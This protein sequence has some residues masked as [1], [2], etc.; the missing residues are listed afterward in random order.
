ML[1]D[2]L[3]RQDSQ[4]RSDSGVILEPLEIPDQVD[5]LG[6][7]DCEDLRVILDLRDQLVARA[8]KASKVQQERL[9]QQVISAA[10]FVHV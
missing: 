4:D 2:S 6:V 9:D 8:L 10:C 5:Q 7:Q 1:P 3:G